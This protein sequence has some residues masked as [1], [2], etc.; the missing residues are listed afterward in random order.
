MKWN[1]R[2]LCLG[3]AHSQ[4]SGHSFGRGRRRTHCQTRKE[5]NSLMETGVK[6]FEVIGKGSFNI[7]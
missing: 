6:L 7:Q 5:R 2:H 4:Q 1:Q 3:K